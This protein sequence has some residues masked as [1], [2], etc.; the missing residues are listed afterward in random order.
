MQILFLNFTLKLKDA[1]PLV[2]QIDFDESVFP[3]MNFVFGNYLLC[4]NEDVPAQYS[5]VA[6]KQKLNWVTLDG[7]RFDHDGSVSGGYIN[8]HESRIKYF[9]EYRA[10]IKECS[11]IDQK[12]KETKSTLLLFLISMFRN[13]LFYFEI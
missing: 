10:I 9:R 7:D 5:S 6:A 2:E 13:Q 1:A 12:I 11:E 3:V 4:K 8:P